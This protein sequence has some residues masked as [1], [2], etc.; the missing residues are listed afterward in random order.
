MN[1]IYSH[2]K[3]RTV[4]DSPT[5]PVNT[6]YTEENGAPLP[7]LDFSEKYSYISNKQDE[8]QPWQ[9]VKRKKSKGAS[10]NKKNTE[11]VC[12]GSK[13]SN[14]ACSFQKASKRRWLYVGEIAGQDVTENDVKSCLGDL[15]D[16][17]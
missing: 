7:P 3:R 4:A 6:G 5:S 16:H 12:N 13:P 1:V 8:I 15:K 2:V 10:F 9:E 14:A 17:D 11:I